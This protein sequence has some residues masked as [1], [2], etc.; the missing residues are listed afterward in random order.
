MKIITAFTNKSFGIGKNNKLPWTLPEDMQRFSK[1]T[2]ENTVVMGKNTWLS[3]DQN[4]LKKRFNIIVSS[5]DGGTELPN[6]VYI[7]KETLEHLEDVINYGDIYIIGGS[8]LYREF[9]GKADTILATII[10]Q[11]F[12]CDT[13]FPV[14]NMHKYDIHLSSTK[15]YSPSSNLNYRFVTYKLRKDNAR[16][17]EYQYL[18]LMRS[19]LTKGEARPD[20][21][22]VGTLAIFGTQMRFDIE[23]SVPFI[24]TKYLAWKMVIYELLWF[25]SGS[26]DSRIL[27][28]NG[29]NIW[30]GNSSREFLDSV[31]LDKYIEGD[32]GPLYSHSFRFFGAE[33]TGCESNYTNKGFDQLKHIIHTLKTDPY[34][35]RHLM[36]TFN[37]SVVDQC[38][39][40]PCHGIAIQFYVSGD[41]EYPYLSCHVYCRSSDTFL[42]LP[43]NIASYSILTYLIAKIVGMRP[44]DLII[45]TGDTHI[46]ASHIEQ[47]KAQLT[48]NP[49]PF[50]KLTINDSVKTKDISE[51]TID[52]FQVDGY[53]YHPSIKA[54]M[55]I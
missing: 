15:L 37:P 22:G 34:S 8:H 35:R 40:M 45:S 26:C 25:L 46:Y 54:P 13:C 38:A 55:A 33:Y 19:I 44:K 6:V 24:T 49:L 36:T 9:V 4:A 47:V 7:K 17:Q 39:L 52:D 43:F 23:H 48:R 18:D 51:I 50:P 42:G 41:E 29:V 31:G 28:K 2:T 20:R 32:I 16:H 12:D 30:K 11:Q 3:L 10:E 14:E 21:T 53:I 1:I 5:E 27:Q